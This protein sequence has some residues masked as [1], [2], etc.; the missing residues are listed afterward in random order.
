MQEGLFAE[1]FAED[2]PDAPQVDFWAVF[3]RS[4]KQFWR[5]VPESDDEL[6]EFRRR[7]AV[8]ARHAEVGDFHLASVVHE[9]VGSLQVAVQDPIAVQVFDGGRELGEESL[10]LRGEEWFGHVFL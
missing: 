7:V 8:V 5:A 9:Q 2:A 6:G 3:L 10:D 4:Q 1:E